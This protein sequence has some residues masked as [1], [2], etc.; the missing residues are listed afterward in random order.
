MICPFMLLNAQHSKNIAHSNSSEQTMRKSNFVVLVETK[1]FEV[2]HQRNL[3]FICWLL[4]KNRLILSNY[5]KDW[6]NRSLPWFW[7]HEADCLHSSV[8]RALEFFQDILSLQNFPFLLLLMI[9]MDKHG[10]FNTFI[11]WC[12]SLIQN[13][14][15]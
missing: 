7:G 4:W 1:F 10:F 3:N 9:S 11:F 8:C 15:C 2:F 6:K 5:F 12:K 13:W 14:S